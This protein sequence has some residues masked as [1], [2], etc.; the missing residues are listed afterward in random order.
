MNARELAHLLGLSERQI[1]RLAA[2]G[3]LS[4]TETGFP[5]E[6]IRQYVEYLRAGDG[7]ALDR[8]R[9]ELLDVRAQQR[10]L[11]LR[12]AAAQ[13]LTVEELNHVIEQVWL[14]HLTAFRG[15]GAALYHH[16]GKVA[17]NYAREIAGGF[18]AQMLAWLA[19]ARD[20]SR[21]A[22]RVALGRIGDPE[23][24]ERLLAELG[25]DDA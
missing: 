2:K 16:A 12:K 18:E 15:I 5:L 1:A 7:G 9:R 25:S 19:T 3:V 21:R 6:A 17:P 8:S 13:T 14:A 11:E 23:R 10:R 4:Q 22:A 20:E 24:I